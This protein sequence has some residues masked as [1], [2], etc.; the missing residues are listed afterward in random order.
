M[1][2]CAEVCGEGAKA[3]SWGGGSNGQGAAGQAS[4][5]YC[6]GT[7]SRE[8]GGHGCGCDVLGL[9]HEGRI[10]GHRPRSADGDRRC[11]EEIAPARAIESKPSG[12]SSVDGSG[13]V[14]GKLV[15]SPL[16][17]GNVDVAGLTQ[18]TEGALGH[19]RSGVGRRSARLLNLKSQVVGSVKAD[20]HRGCIPTFDEDRTRREKRDLAGCVL[21][22]A[23]SQTVADLLH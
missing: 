5:L 18:A 6:D 16:C 20:G 8:V 11:N 15:E 17:V 14:E 19:G 23:R 4:D 21:N 22:R 13:E 7:A 1:Q 9:P 3:I 12:V 10:N 2:A